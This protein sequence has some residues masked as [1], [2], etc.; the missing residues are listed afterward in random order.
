MFQDCIEWSS[1]AHE[2]FMNLNYS[3]EGREQLFVKVSLNFLFS[4]VIRL[5]WHLSLN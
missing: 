5:S 4:N 1:N 3:E 2:C